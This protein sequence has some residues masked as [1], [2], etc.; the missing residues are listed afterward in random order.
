MTEERKSLQASA[1]FNFENTSNTNS[2]R[3]VLLPGIFQT[4]EIEKITRSSTDY[5]YVRN[6]CKDSLTQANYVADQVADDYIAEIGRASCRE[7]V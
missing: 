2:K 5:Y 1:T 3:L 6:T 4:T 7:R